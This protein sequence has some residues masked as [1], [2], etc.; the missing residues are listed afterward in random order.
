M[1]FPAYWTGMNRI[2]IDW[3]GYTMCSDISATLD[4]KIIKKGCIIHQQ[5]PLPGRHR[6]ALWVC[7][8][9]IVPTANVINIRHSIYKSSDGIFL[10]RHKD[11]KNPLPNSLCYPAKHQGTKTAISRSTLLHQEIVSSVERRWTGHRA[12]DNMKDLQD[13]MWL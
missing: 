12:I 10:Q 2:L 5:Q 7:L 13:L 3:K 4:L 11:E 8:F 6:A 1:L 9:A